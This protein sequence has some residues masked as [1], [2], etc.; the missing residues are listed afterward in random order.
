MQ[1]TRFYQTFSVEMTL[2]I[3]L[4]FSSWIARDPWKNVR[5]RGPPQDRPSRGDLKKI[6]AQLQVALTFFVF[7]IFYDFFYRSIQILTAERIPSIK[8]SVHTLEGR[9]RGGPRFVRIVQRSLRILFWIDPADHFEF[10]I[11][12]K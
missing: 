7:N 1:Q 12:E 4:R 2:C 3:A 10:V 6:E 5:F 11:N 8:V 9:S